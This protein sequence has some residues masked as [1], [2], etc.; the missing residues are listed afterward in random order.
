MLDRRAGDV[1]E[2]CRAIV[3]DDL[4]YALDTVNSGPAAHTLG[5]SLLSDREKGTLAT[6]LPG[7]V[8]ES[9]VGNKAAGYE[10]KFSIGS[11]HLHRDLGQ[12]FWKHLPGWLE[13]GKIRPLRYR[14]IRGIDEKAVNEALDGYRDG[15]SVVKV[16]IHPHESP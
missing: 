13:A 11:G 6:L 1:A 4:L 9:T 2:Q 12:Q 5:V 3:G 8:A 7:D 14:T 15:G 10:V 16:N